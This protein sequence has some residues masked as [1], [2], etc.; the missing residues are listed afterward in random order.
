MLVGVLLT[1]RCQEGVPG[2]LGFRTIS[3]G[4]V[5]RLIGGIGDVERLIGRETKLGLELLN[6][7]SLKR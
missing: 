6:I 7:V 1:V 3:S 5:V 4:G 2:R